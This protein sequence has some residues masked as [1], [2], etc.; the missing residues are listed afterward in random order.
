[1]RYANRRDANDAL[2]IEYVEA[3]G[4]Q[5]WQASPPAPFDYFVRRGSNPL[6]VFLEIKTKLGKLTP[7]QQDFR[8]WLG[9][10]PFVT[11]RT[12]EEAVRGLQE[13]L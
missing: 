7:N 5:T 12:P 11:A 6:V 9:K 2:I 3:C 10:G 13:W 1:M 8:D 4:Y